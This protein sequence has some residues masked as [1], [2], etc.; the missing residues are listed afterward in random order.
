MRSRISKS[1]MVIAIVTIVAVLAMLTPAS[2]APSYVV[3]VPGSASAGYATRQVVLQQGSNLKFLNLDIALHDVDHLGFPKLFESAT[4][5]IGK[6]TMVLRAN[7]LKK[8]VYTFFCTIHPN[9]KGKLRV[10]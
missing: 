3:A 10:I 8:G 1:S 5:G 4:I 6:Q 2:A 9:M 7:L